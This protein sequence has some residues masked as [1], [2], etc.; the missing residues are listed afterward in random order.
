MDTDLWKRLEEDFH[1]AIE[2]PAKDRAAYVKRVSAGD[3]RLGDELRS[4]LASVDPIF[5]ELP[6]LGSQEGWAPTARPTLAVGAR[7]RDFQIIELVGRGG[8]G[9]VYRARDERL[10]REVALKFLTAELIEDPSFLERFR[11]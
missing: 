7:V 8:M 2:L 3:S 9:D 11:A 5:L 1:H 10:K 4:L 6:P